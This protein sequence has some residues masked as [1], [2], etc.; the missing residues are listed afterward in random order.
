MAV[1]NNEALIMDKLIAE[2]RDT[3][4]GLTLGQRRQLKIILGL[5]ND[6]VDSDVAVTLVDLGLVVKAGDTYRGT[7]AGGYVCRLY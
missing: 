5:L 2:L 6:H 3:C 1:E 4:E 7:P